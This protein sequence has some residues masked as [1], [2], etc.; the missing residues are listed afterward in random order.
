M[1]YFL[2]ILYS[3]H[4]QCYMWI[5]FVLGSAQPHECPQMHSYWESLRCSRLRNLPFVVSDCLLRKPNFAYKRSLSIWEAAISL[6]LSLC[7]K[8]C[9]GAVVSVPETGNPYGDGDRLSQNRRK[10]PMA[11]ARI[12]D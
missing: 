2:F 6:G 11:D 7:D 9:P 3:Q 12:P 4:L 8:R 10:D 1:Y 5:G